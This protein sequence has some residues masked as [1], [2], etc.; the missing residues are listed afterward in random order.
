MMS[1]RLNK[2]KVFLSHSKDD[3]SFINQ[4]YND[5]R[6]CQIEPWLDSEEI[7]HGKPWL[8]AIFEDGLPTCDSVLVYFTE[9]SLKSAMVK[10][11]IDSG[12]LQQLKE[13]S[14][15]FLPYVNDAEIRSKLRSDIQALQVVEWNK[16]NYFSLLPQV[17]AEIWRSF[18]ERMILNAIKNERIRR[19]EAELELE[20]I[21]NSTKDEV[22]SETENS[23]FEYIWEK[24][25]RFESINFEEKKHTGE[26]KELICNHKFTVHIGS[27]IPFISD[28]TNS[29]YRRYVIY[30]LLINLLK[31]HLMKEKNINNKEYSLE[32]KSYPD[33]GN[34]LLMYGFTQRV[35]TPSTKEENRI[36]RIINMPPCDI[37]F[38]YSEKIDR[39]KYWLAY[40]GLLPK[41]VIWR[42]EN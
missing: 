28:I 30:N 31:S 16:D 37:K 27:L 2:P 41:E 5:L 35:H 39:F 34:E 19:L 24:L 33:I 32:I 4:L 20:K 14:I 40:K 26:N 21:K 42:I 3:I 22:F 12:L 13:N 7:R 8:D 15:S 25:D 17:V 6:K 29:D 11:E 36:H 23:D 9:Y 18:S 38:I 10:K 1:S